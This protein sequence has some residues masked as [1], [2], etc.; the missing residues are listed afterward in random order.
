MPIHMQLE[1]GP[2]GVHCHHS[3]TPQLALPWHLQQVPRPRLLQSPLPASNMAPEH[4]A[5]AAVWPTLAMLAPGTMLGGQ[6][7]GPVLN[8]FKFARQ[9]LGCIL[10]WLQHGMVA[11]WQGCSVAQLNTWHKPQL[12][13]KR[14]RRLGCKTG[15]RRL[16][17]PWAHGKQSQPQMQ[18]YAN[19]LVCGTH[20][21]RV[22]HMWH[23]AT[24]CKNVIQKCDT[25][26]IANLYYNNVIQMPTALQNQPHG[27]DASV[28]HD[29]TPTDY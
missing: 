7:I 8:N 16:G 6:F 20:T 12:W 13:H 4:T 2:F 14:S 21:G 29:G 3:A 9:W 11:A 17:W 27:A 25:K 19:R 22:V 10:Q 15:S 28:A 23:V 18:H 26:H 5:S 1:A 24:Q